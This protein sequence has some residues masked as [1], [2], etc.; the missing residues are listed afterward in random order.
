MELDQTEELFHN[1][2]KFAQKQFGFKKPPTLNLL[3]DQ[4]N[5]SKPLGKTAY[6]DPQNMSISIYVDGRHPKDILRSFAHEL[7]HHTQNENGQLNVSGYSGQ[8][9]AQK[10]KNLRAMERDAY[11]RGNMCFRDWEDQLKQSKPTIYNERRNYKMSTKKWKNKELS[12]NLSERFG[13]KMNLSALNESYDLK[14]ESKEED[15]RTLYQQ[16]FDDAMAG[17][18]PADDAP[19]EPLEGGYQDGYNAGEEKRISQDAEVGRRLQNR[20]KDQD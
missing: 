2:G 12:E 4:E 5:Q 3:S 6:Y 20:R 7:V 1:L 10:N 17:L 14:G 13:I 11:E 8:G 18:E 19:R 9:Y 15:Q 16:G